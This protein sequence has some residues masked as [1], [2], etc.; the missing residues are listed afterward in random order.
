MTL[1]HAGLMCAT[2]AR[3]M[4]VRRDHDKVTQVYLGARLAAKN[5]D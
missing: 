5:T 1:A 3:H 2:Y 4:R